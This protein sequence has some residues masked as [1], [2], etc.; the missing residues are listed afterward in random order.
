[1]VILDKFFEGRKIYMKP[2][3]ATQ[4]TMAEIIDNKRQFVDMRNAINKLDKSLAYILVMRTTLTVYSVM[5]NI[6]ILSVINEIPRLDAYAKLLA[7]STISEISATITSSFVCGSVHEKSD[8]IYA[9]LDEFNAKDLSDNE[10][11]EWHMFKT[12]SD[13]T[14]FGFTI[15]GFASLRKTTLIA[16]R[17]KPIILNRNPLN[18]YSFSYSHL[19]STIL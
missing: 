19:F 8:Q 2:S 5:V 6:H 7:F 16:V 11:K 3:R 13:R 9:V 1:M 17:I 14:R 15:G 10:Y 4:L 18:S 12:V